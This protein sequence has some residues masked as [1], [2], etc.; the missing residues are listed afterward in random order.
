MVGQ[1]QQYAMLC[2]GY[3]THVLVLYAK[4]HESLLASSGGFS[5]SHIASGKNSIEQIAMGGG[6]CIVSNLSIN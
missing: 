6:V 4:T 5:Y 2:K 3:S 1:L